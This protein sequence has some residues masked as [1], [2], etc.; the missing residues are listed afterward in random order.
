MVH[1]SK[2]AWEILIANQSLCVINQTDWR[3]TLASGMR[4]SHG[5]GTVHGNEKKHGQKSD[6]SSNPDRQQFSGWIIPIRQSRQGQVAFV[7]CNRSE[8]MCAKFRTRPLHNRQA[9]FKSTQST[10][11]PDMQLQRTVDFAERQILFQ[12]LDKKLECGFAVFHIVDFD[13]GD[14]RQRL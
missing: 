12:L 3:R 14:C 8:Q 1:K 4:E 9:V 2:I 10:A 11:F 7:I 13:R 5:V 6:F